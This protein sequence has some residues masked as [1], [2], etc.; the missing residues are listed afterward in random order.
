MA[1]YR[2][3]GLSLPLLSAALALVA[4]DETTGQSDGPEDKDGVNI[5][6]SPGKSSGASMGAGGFGEGGAGGAGQACEDNTDCIISDPCTI[7]V[8]TSEKVCAH[9]DKADDNNACTDDACDPDTGVV[10]HAPV[11][12]D[13]AN[14]CTFDSC[15]PVTGPTHLPGRILFTEDFSDNQAVWTLGAQW[16]IGSAAPSSGG[17]NGGNDPDVDHTMTNDDGVA[18][19]GQG[20]LVT[21]TAGPSYL[22]S[23]PITIT[24]VPTTEFV[25]LDFFRWLNADAPPEMTAFIEAFNGTSFVTV[26]TN[27]TQVFDAPPLGTGWLEVRVDMTAEALACQAANTP[28]RF[29]FGFTKGAAMPSIGGWNIDDLTLFHTRIATDDDVCTLDVCSDDGNGNPT[30]TFSAIT[31]IDDG[32]DCTDF[33]CVLNSGPQQQPN[34]GPGCP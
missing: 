7:D 15:D 22:T 25:T 30:A 19:S 31:P 1:S 6:P 32:D 13:D 27:S 26:W 20:L 23:P 4:C 18:T 16:V 14:V 34:G 3:L 8:C 24:G 12:V 2:A 33:N 9:L 11:A 28:F 5:I 10:T 17:L 29:R 21:T